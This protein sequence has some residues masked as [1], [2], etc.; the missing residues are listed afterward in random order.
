[1]LLKEIFSEITHDVI[2]VVGAGGK[3]SFINYF[4]NFYREKLDVLLTTTTKI[5]LPNHKE[6][7]TLYM[8]RSNKK[9][10]VIK[11]PGVTV[12][13]KYINEDNKIIGLDYK[14]IKTIEEN[15]EL[16]LI[17]GDGS[18]KKKLKGWRDNEPVIYHSSKKVV[19]IVD[20]TAFD[21][22]I[23]D[24]NIH[25][26]KEFIEITN[27]HESKVTLI[28]LKNMILNKDGLFKNAIGEK[29]L[30]INKVESDRYKKLAEGL[31]K[32]INEDSH[33]ISIFYGS[34]KENF[35]KVG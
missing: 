18:K 4:A 14:E 22:D 28:H 16:I 34:I 29:V 9:L 23:N 6:Y 20:I 17:E 27:L 15:F 11:S 12:A 31:I 5:Y 2:T 13:G 19:G 32:L 21:M 8:T 10:D 7:D 30:F 1:M 26:L 35:C 3:T 24:N 25:N 33:N